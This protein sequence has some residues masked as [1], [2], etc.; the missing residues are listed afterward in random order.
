MAFT[1]SLTLRR[2]VAHTSII[3]AFSL[4]YKNFRISDEYMMLKLL[5]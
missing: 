3:G 1:L 4:S 2:I 5:L